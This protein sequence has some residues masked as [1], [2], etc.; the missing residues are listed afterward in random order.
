MD[1]IFSTASTELFTFGEEEVD[2]WRTQ[3]PRDFL[4]ECLDRP[5]V[6][7]CG[8][9]AVGLFETSHNYLEDSLWLDSLWIHPTHRHKGYGTA[10][11]DYLVDTCQFGKI[12]LFSANYSDPF[13]EERGFI[14]THGK[15]YERRIDD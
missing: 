9:N 12:K 4:L 1:L 2:K 14:N 13:Y 15:Y 5:V 11:L 7:F 10:I 6:A 3:Y 8:A